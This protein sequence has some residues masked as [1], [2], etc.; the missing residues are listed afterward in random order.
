MIF[1]Y[2][3]LSITFFIISYFLL[4]ATIFV[5]SYKFFLN[6]FIALEGKQNQNDVNTFLS[7]LNENI[8]NLKNTT[9]DYSKWDDTY[10]F[11]KDKNE[12]YLYEN[13][14]EGA[15]TLSGLNLDAIIYTNLKDEVMF[16]KYNNQYLE[17]NQVDFEKYLLTKF[18]NKNNI[19]EVVNYNSNFIYLSKSEILKSDYTGD[20]R[21]FVLTVKLNT[22]EIF[23][24][25]YSIFK[26]ISIKENNSKLDHTAID[27]EYLKT[28]VTTQLDS[29]Y[30]INDIRFLDNHGKYIL[31]LITT[32]ERNLIHN[33][34]KTIYSF[35]LIIFIII[36][37]I[38]LFIYKNQYLINNQNILLNEE[39]EKRTKQLTIA[40]RNLDEINKELYKNA[41]I[42]YLTGIKNRRSYFEEAPTLLKESIL[43]NHSFYVLMID[44]D[45]FKKIN[46]TYGHSVGDK[47]LINFCNIVNKIIDEKDLFARIGGE[48]FCITFYNKDLSQI[49]KISQNIIEAC[50]QNKLT[51]NN[52]KIT[53]TVSLG[54]SSRNNLN[55]IDKILHQA[56]ESLYL[57]KTSGKNCLVIENK[58]I[59]F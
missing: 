21:G 5:V 25:N 47:I 51:F 26:N 42:D 36:F 23:S 44:I 59:T 40:Y 38:F 39:V 30:L 35:N 45:N 27:F 53:F 17:S 16:S 31:S 3:R 12:S 18:K 14:R 54:L 4:C 7:S 48:E 52:Q 15:Q 11:A 41:N 2:I 10:N 37:F 43:K 56:D 57:A 8:E 50:A 58:K 29:N 9:N 1:K 22:N 33:S 6:D 20:V 13:F 19:N 34:K 32:S 28:K 55:V 46:D 49:T 24:K